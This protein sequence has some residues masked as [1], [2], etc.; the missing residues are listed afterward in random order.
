MVAENK[1]EA[2]ADLSPTSKERSCPTWGGFARRCSIHGCSEPNWEQWEE[3]E[4][5]NAALLVMCKN[6][7]ETGAPMI[8]GEKGRGRGRGKGFLQFSE[9]ISV[10]SPASPGVPAQFPSAALP[11]GRMKPH[12]QGV[13]VD[14]DRPHQPQKSQGRLSADN[15]HVPVHGTP[16]CS[17]PRNLLKSSFPHCLHADW[18]K[19]FPSPQQ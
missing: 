15:I 10:S 5:R 19:S 1:S 4:F 18:E 14:P 3:Q 11:A 8:Q 16:A 6:E 7:L 17:A 12:F 13:S 9:G 2:G